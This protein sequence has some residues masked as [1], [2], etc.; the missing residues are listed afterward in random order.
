MNA[1]R[2]KFRIT[3]NNHK[4]I[5]VTGGSDL[6]DDGAIADKWLVEAAL[7]LTG[8]IDGN[9]S[10]ADTHYETQ[11]WDPD[12]S[13][14]NRIRDKNLGLVKFA[15][16]GVTATAVANAGAAYAEAKN[17][18]YRYEFPANITTENGAIEHINDTL[19]R[20]DYAVATLPSWCDMTDP[21]ADGEPKL[22]TV[23]NVGMIHGWEARC[24]ANFDGYHKAAAG[25]DATLP[26]IVTIPTGDVILN[27]ELLNPVGISVIKKKK[28]NFVLWG[29]R[30]CSIST[31]WRFKHHRELM[32][33]YEQTLME[34][35][36]YVVFAI[37]DAVEQKPLLNALRI[38]FRPEWNKRALRGKTFDEAAIIKID[39]E[40]NT[41]ATMADG[42]MFADLSLK[43]ADTIERFR[44]RIGK[45]GLFEST[46]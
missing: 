5:T 25:V 38:F 13:P 7:R 15:T 46:T 35:F 42:D 34:S 4:T 1:K 19:G 12:S 8:G 17:H 9:A 45:Q 30:T 24:A 18:Q 39:D 10:V 37:N 21:D 33:Y 36:D 26:Q 29:D 41:D 6:T 43:L 20:N 14:F 44:I 3:D 32:S 22:K 2:T 23:P 31:E 11:A 28:G 27:E 40:N 16:P